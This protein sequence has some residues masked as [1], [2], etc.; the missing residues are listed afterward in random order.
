MVV[1]RRCGRLGVVAVLLGAALTGCI[2]VSDGED[3]AMTVSPGTLY[4][5]KDTSARKPAVLVFGG[6]E[7][8]LSYVVSLEAAMLAAHGYPT[9][10]LAY[11]GAP[12]LPPKLV[13]IPLEYFR[14]G[15]EILRAQ[16]AVDP[17]HV[18]VTSASY[19]GE[20]SL[21]VAATFPDL[22][23]GVIAVAP[24]SFVSADPDGQ[25]RAAWS[26]HG[27]DLPRGTFGVPA[28]Q[29]DPRALIPLG[30]I[31]GPILM[32]CGPLDTQW[33]ACRNVDDAL[34]RLGRRPGVTV[35][36]YPGAGHYVSAIQPYTAVTD[37]LLTRS[38][39]TVPATLGANVDLHRRIL[40]LL[41][42]Q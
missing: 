3:A 9:L 15:L 12:G 16:P 42:A 8:G 20:A 6:S 31:R 39:G 32:A 14:K 30:R 4:S 29:V 25:N 23:N 34:A 22:V 40:A 37:A 33:Q 10:A 36:R 7:G 2:S 24:N 18:L 11:F 38:G 28:A 19:G 21:L 27:R 35:A 26:L 41:A 1:R 5:P 17:G 13:G